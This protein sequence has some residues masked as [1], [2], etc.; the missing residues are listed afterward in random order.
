MLLNVCQSMFNKMAYYYD[1][2]RII[3]LSW[4]SCGHFVGH[5]LNEM[6]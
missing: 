1:C 2:H 3:I 5:Q 4:F 6:K